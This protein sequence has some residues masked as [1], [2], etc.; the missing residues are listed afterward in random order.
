MTP[1]KTEAEVISKFI[2]VSVKT[3]GD[4]I[5][6]LTEKVSRTHP[7]LSRNSAGR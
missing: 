7:F 4:I 1:A 6:L 2:A 5:P 3:E